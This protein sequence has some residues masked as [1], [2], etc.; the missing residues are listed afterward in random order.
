MAFRK[1]HILF[2]NRWH[3]RGQDYLGTGYPDISWHGKIAWQPDWSEDSR[4]LAFMLDGGHAWGGTKEDNSIYV[5]TNTHWD[6]NDVELPGL[7]E[8]KRWH[9]FANTGA[10][11]PED[12]W[13]PGSE[14]V[15][16]DQSHLFLGPR[17][18]AILLAK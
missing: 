15:L 9:V 5:V 4:L 11:T 10:S 8:G 7:P 1:E 2:H 13:E 16:S 6:A 14:P 3:L 18:V 17:S 12:I